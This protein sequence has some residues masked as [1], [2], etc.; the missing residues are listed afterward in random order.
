MMAC[1]EGQRRHSIAN[2]PVALG[3]CANRNDL[4]RKFVA[5]RRARR[6]RAML[7]YMGVGTPGYLCA[8][9]R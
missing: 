4:V 3:A 2:P 8:P 7:G 1:V 5:R 6:H 9:P